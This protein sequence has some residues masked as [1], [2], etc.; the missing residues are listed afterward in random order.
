[1]HTM[2][3]FMLMVHMCILPDIHHVTFTLTGHIIAFPSL[4]RTCDR[5]SCKT[6]SM[7]VVWDGGSDDKP[8]LRSLGLESPQHHELFCFHM[9]FQVSFV[10]C[11][12]FLLPSK[13]GLNKV[14]DRLSKVQ[15]IK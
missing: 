7:E 4:I 12:L 14:T 3:V 15:V 13:F 6:L 11:V 5:Q 8:S 9:L 1:M 2:V 10:Q